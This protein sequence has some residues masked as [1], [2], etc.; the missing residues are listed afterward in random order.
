MLPLPKNNIDPAQRRLLDLFDRLNEP[1]RATLTAFAEFL[2]GRA[3]TQ[4]QPAAQPS[5]P[6]EPEQIP[7]PPKESVVGAIKRLTKVYP[8]LPREALLNETSDLMSAHVLQGRP[9][10]DVINE[11]ESLFREHYDRYRKQWDD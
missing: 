2:A 6:L 11:L 1:D 7:R 8:M 3:E 9:A 10:A 5:R 4:E